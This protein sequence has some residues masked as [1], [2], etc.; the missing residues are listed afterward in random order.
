DVAVVGLGGMGA[1][2]LAQF[3][4]RGARAIGIDRYPRG[5]ALGA[6]TG[7]TRV[8]RK[9][10]FEN[11]AYV[12]LLER[13]YELWLD[14]QRRARR[15]LMDPVGMLMVG[16]PEREGIAGTLRAAREYDLP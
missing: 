1:A 8:I 10:Y 9:A 7:E 3:A 12:P 2:T 6:S 16:E 5:H 14:L 15:R 4:R 13:A 11:P